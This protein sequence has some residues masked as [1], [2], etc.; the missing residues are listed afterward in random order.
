MFA[1]SVTSLQDV[2]MA[3]TTDVLSFRVL[4]RQK[5]GRVRRRR[6]S[7]R[8]QKGLNKMKH[9]LT[10]RDFL[11]LIGA[12][13]AALA[14]PAGL[15]AFA[16]DGKKPNLVLIVADDLGWGELGCQGNRQ[17]PTPHIDSIAKAGVRFTSG[18][19]SCPVC[20]PTRAG[21]MT[22]RY[23]QRFGHEF[24]PGPAAGAE[25]GLP[26]SQT[27]I[28]KRLK[29]VGYVT[30]MVGKW[31]LGN[32]EKFRPLSRGFDEFFGFLGGAHQYFPQN[33]SSGTGN[34][35]IMRGN[36]AIEE[37][38]YLTDAFRREAVAFIEKHKA[39]PF[40]LYLPFNAVHA[41]LQAPRKY[42]DRFAEIKEEKR[43][44]WAAMLSAMDDAVGAV[45]KTLRDNGLE[46]NTL[47]IFFSDNGGPTQSTTSG[48][49][50]LR[51]YKGQVLE[52][53]VRVAYMMQW[54]GTI[55]SGTVDDRPVIQL[56]VAPTLLAAAGG[57]APSEA[58]DGVDLMPYIKTAGDSKGA[59]HKAL[60]WRF[61]EQDAIRKG[62]WKL[63]DVGAGSELYNLADDIGEK[64]NLAA[65]NP[66][67]VKELEAELEVWKMGLAAPLWK[68][69]TQPR[70]A[71]RARA[72]RRANQK[73]PAPVK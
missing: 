30:G 63:L 59:P 16:A 33:G 73:A 19:V 71:R 36:K 23:Q 2:E 38:D 54:K 5:T 14:V 32:Q 44:T 8:R 21:L 61:G 6:T 11:K 25:F 69:Q 50:P 57:K 49:G 31:H 15:R 64:T 37:K 66:E 45:L 34:N 17:I 9:D 10:R 48:N 46:E 35:A 7:C 29:D 60:C 43:R 55:P 27:T 3:A 67:K 28:A 24:N 53:G 51:G 72:K 39:E 52:G 42:L 70:P 41:P 1:E 56:D 65:K 12:G 20:S 58:F 4:V 62:D 26:L 68:R 22:G 40:F 47:V 13:S 18:Y